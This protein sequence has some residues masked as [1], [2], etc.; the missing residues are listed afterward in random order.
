VRK[1]LVEALRR[2]RR[3]I[4]VALVT[5]AAVLCGWQLWRAHAGE[6][7]GRLDET[8]NQGHRIVDRRGRLM[9]ELPSEAGARGRPIALDDVGDRLV[10]ATLVAEDKRFYEHG[11]VDPRAIV[12]ALGQ[13]A[14]HLRLVSGASTITQQLV[15]LLDA[16][17]EAPGDRTLYVKAREA[18]RAENLEEELTKSQ[19]LEAYLNRLNYGR[20]L[21]GPEAAAQAYFGVSPRDLSW[22]QA[23]LLAVLPRAPSAL[24]P[25][26]HLDRAL[27]R[28]RVLLDALRDE[29]ILPAADHGRAT[30][31]VISIRP[32]EHPFAAP[33]LVEAMRQ[34]NH[35]GLAD[36]PTTVT[37]L[38]LDLQRDVEGLCD[39][40]VERLRQKNASS[41]AIVVIDNASGE[42]LA[43]VGGAGFDDEGHGQVDMARARRQPGSALKPF[44]YAMAFE[45][46]VEPTA[47]LA[48]VPTRFG[49]RAGAWAPVNFD[50]TFWGPVSAREALA[51]SLNIPAVRIAAGLEEGSLLARLHRLGIESLDRPASHYG[52]ALV[53]G[54]GEV[55]LVEL[56]QAYAALARGGE[57][58]AL[59]FRADDPAA[60][61]A[62]QRGDRLF[63]ASAAASVTD[64]LSDPQARIRG[65]GNVGP[66]DVGFP[67]AVKTGTSSGYRDGWS[68]GFTRER[69]VA[70]WVGNP[71]GRPT[72]E[73]T[74]GAGAGPLFADVMRRAMRDVAPRAPLWDE[75]LLE[76]V[77]VCPLSGKPV[78]NA[79][80]D[81]VKRRVPAGHEHGGA[82]EL[83]HH[84]S[85]RPAA[86]GEVPWMCDPHG[87]AVIVTLPAELTAWL[88]AQPPGAPGR[89]LVGLPWF[90][91]AAVPGCADAPETAPF[92][93][94]EDPAPGSVLLAGD[95]AAVELAAALVGS[96]PSLGVEFVLDGRVVASVKRPP[97]RTHVAALRGDHELVVRPTDPDAAVRIASTR[98]SVR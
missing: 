7:S 72:A 77:E 23:A 82:C 44:A 66:F 22:A 12:R 59:R 45:R 63:D 73:L 98:F 11:G 91:A 75:G 56:G 37:T 55:T 67:V 36:G 52:L 68:V 13:N 89:D 32:L 6:P 10:V 80:P 39:S 49:E 96:A 88:A 53:L 92:L 61:D 38:D 51:G 79:C 81:A 93:R 30:A 84:A 69:T 71:D 83:H 90:P 8:W 1:R 33:Y 58:V 62:P 50:G 97:Y 25:Y 9:R 40:H 43:Y 57:G 60:L 5:L 76:E 54:S 24:D 17:G 74:G 65:L 26:D 70:V 78:T 19:I 86:H 85:P 47:M 64:I 94:I 35:G 16:G 27:P 34:G 87:S 15:K 4:A 2:R 28:Q 41:A 42:V 95:G 20:G 18:A 14:A 31:E 29:G 3:R 21:V 46:G 48:D